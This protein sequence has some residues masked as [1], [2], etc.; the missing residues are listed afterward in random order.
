MA[1]VT[2][3]RDMSY[4]KIR[5]YFNV[6]LRWQPKICLFSYFDTHVTYVSLSVEE[7]YFL[8]FDE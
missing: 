6:L 3:Q 5:S 4:I 2:D 8:H 7:K 1:E